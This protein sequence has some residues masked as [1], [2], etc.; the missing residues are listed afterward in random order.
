MPRP[1]NGSLGIKHF[2]FMIQPFLPSKWLILLAVALVIFKT[3]L[4]LII[5]LIAKGFIDGIE[6]SIINVKMIVL[7]FGVFFGQFVISSFSIYTMNYIGQQVVLSL[8]GHIWEKILHLPI[9][10]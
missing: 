1:K 3:V 9:S 10:F 2:K 4:S 6:Y 5:P 7:L 8:R